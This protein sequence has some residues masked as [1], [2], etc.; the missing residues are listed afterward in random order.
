MAYAHRAKII[1]RDLK[2]ANI[3]LDAEGGFIKILDFGVA[4]LAA[5]PSAEATDLHVEPTIG[6]NPGTPNYM[7]PEQLF[8]RGV[9]A[10]SDIYSAGVILFQMATGRP[11][12]AGATAPVVAAAILHEQP[13]APSTLRSELTPRFDEVILNALE[14]DHAFLLKGDV[15]TTDFLEMWLSH[16]RKEHDALR[17][18]PHPYEFFLYYDV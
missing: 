13:P 1:H 2:P 7:A 4:K 16:K 17:L 12:F 5:A 11:A 15:F 3:M 18:W 8:G 14:K 9:D 6:G 10:R